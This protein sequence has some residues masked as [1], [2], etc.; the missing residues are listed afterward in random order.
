M[1]EDPLDEGVSIQL[2]GSGNGSV[3]IGPTN[4]MQIWIPTMAATTVSSNV[5]EPTLKL[6][7]GKTASGGG[8]IGGTYTASN[9]S[10]DLNGYVLYPND[11]ILAVWT[12]GDAGAIA[13]IKLY[14]KLL[15]P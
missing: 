14:G 1:H 3:V 11:G 10:T 15:T 13:T 7:R 4:P 8:Y 12:G 6:Y 5:N 9:D 2:N